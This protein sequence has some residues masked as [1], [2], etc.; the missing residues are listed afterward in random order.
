MKE[1]K[2]NRKLGYTLNINPEETASSSETSLFPG[3][4]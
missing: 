1:S 4:L 3:T 2:I